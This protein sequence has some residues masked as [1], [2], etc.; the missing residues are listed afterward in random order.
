MMHQLTSA[1]ISGV[2]SIVA[3]LRCV[4]GRHKTLDEAAVAV[5]AA[6]RGAS[7]ASSQSK[8]QVRSR[9]ALVLPIVTG[10]V[11][12]CFFYGCLQP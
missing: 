5:L 11:Q 1:I 4:L 2:A 9:L 6:E 3:H 8:K 10:C 12:P 7:E